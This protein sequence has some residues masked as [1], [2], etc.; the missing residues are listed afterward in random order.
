MAR[1][2]ITYPLGWPHGHG[3]AE[4]EGRAT[5]DEDGEI[6]VEL[7]DLADEYVPLSG[8]DLEMAVLWL[9]NDPHYQAKIREATDDA[10]AG[11]LA[12][13]RELARAE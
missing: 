12:Y 3:F 10:R 4:V 7:L 11:R 6:E 9:R 5:V 1:F 8:T 2:D 13:D